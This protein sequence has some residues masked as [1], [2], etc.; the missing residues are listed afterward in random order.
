MGQLPASPSSP[1]SGLHTQTGLQSTQ[2]L[3]GDTL[4]AFFPRVSPDPP[5]VQT[6][7]GQ[8]LHSQFL[9]HQKLQTGTVG[10]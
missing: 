3:C 2:C 9:V 8:R 7:P 5:H 10:R 4:C 6:G 1:P